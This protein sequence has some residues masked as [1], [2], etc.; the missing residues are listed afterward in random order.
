M[1]VLVYLETY[2]V[3]TTITVEASSLFVA[4]SRTCLSLR[5]RMVTGNVTTRVTDEHRLVDGLGVNL[6]LE[7]SDSQDPR[8]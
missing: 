4:G 6:I 5:S 1:L 3:L 8:I 7:K 2:R